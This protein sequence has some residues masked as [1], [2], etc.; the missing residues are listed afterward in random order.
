MKTI[1]TTATLAILLAVDTCSGD[2]KS[3]ESLSSEIESSIAKIGIKNAEKYSGKL[4]D[5]LTLEIAAK[6]TGNDLST[7]EKDYSQVFEDPKTH[8]VSYGWTNG[9]K[10]ITDLGFTTIETDKSDM[11]SLSWVS[12]MSPENFKAMYREITDE[13]IQNAQAAMEQR[14]NEGNLDP[15]AKKLAME[16]AA[17]FMERDNTREWIDGVGDM[18]VWIPADKSLKVFN[19]GLTFSL[20]ADI[21]DDNAINRAA[22]IDISKLIIK[23]KL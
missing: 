10:L 9:R 3:N 21:S 15:E 22:A 11:V 23:E 17:G 14:V 20:F 7:A 8:S 5:L 18:A 2:K 13:D 1:L 6:V 4:D 12:T 16:M 19:Q